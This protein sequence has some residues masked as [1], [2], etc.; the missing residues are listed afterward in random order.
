LIQKIFAV[1]LVLILFMIM[2]AGRKNSY[3]TITMS[4]L[5]I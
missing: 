4:K 5:I 1:F 3:G 2:V